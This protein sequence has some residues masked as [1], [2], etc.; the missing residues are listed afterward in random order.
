MERKKGLLAAGCLLA[1]GAAAAA[2]FGLAHEDHT[3]SEA[4]AA[5]FA[6]A[7]PVPRCPH[8]LRRGIPLPD[9]GLPLRRG[10]ADAGY[11][12]GHLYDQIRRPL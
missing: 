4:D 2:W 6:S 10:G 5:V 11:C 9:G 1:V 8:P 3:L 7:S 12:G